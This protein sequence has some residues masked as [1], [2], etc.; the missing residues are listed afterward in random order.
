MPKEAGM[1][2]TAWTTLGL[3]VALGI[4]MVT[5]FT[6][7][8]QRLDSMSARFDSMSARFDERLDSMSARF[9]ERLD[10]MSA[11]FDERLDSVNARIDLVIERLD[12]TNE[13]LARH[14]Q[15]HAASAG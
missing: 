2:V 3:V 7:L 5:L 9:D 11:R 14:L 8:T 1:A 15:E 13:R 12:R 6:M 10:S 4:G